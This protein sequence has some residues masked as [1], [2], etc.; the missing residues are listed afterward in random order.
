VE[1]VYGGRAGRFCQ[2]SGAGHRWLGSS[3]ERACVVRAVVPLARQ[4]VPSAGS[5]VYEMGG[6]LGVR[7]PVAG[8]PSPQPGVG[9]V[10]RRELPCP[11]LRVRVEMGSQKCGIVG[12]SQ[13]VLMMI[14]R[15]C[16]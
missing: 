7:G 14:T 16:L 6:R 1:A 12:K 8:G 4:I 2:L 13:S 5:W 9:G 3:T 15:T 10:S 11:S